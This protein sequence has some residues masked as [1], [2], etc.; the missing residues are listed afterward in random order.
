MMHSPT[1][2]GSKINKT[3]GNYS[4]NASVQTV[5]NDRL[6]FSYMKN[7]E[8]LYTNEKQNDCTRAL[9]HFQNRLQL[10]STW[11]VYLK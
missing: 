4:I 7:S 2:Y 6:T 11:I 10:W 8:I 5:K 1:N 3:N 9:F